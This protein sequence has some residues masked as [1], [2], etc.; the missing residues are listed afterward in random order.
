MTFRPDGTAC[1]LYHEEI[2]LH[3]LGA[4]KCERVSW[5]EFDAD[6]Q[7]WQVLLPDSDIV[8]FRSRRRQRCL[9]WERA[10][11]ALAV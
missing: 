2:D 6:T 8:L 9:D 4:L 11:F 3:T 7:Q 1:C 5:I 10:H